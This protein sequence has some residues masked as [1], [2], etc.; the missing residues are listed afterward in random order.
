MESSDS[1]E[2]P[3]DKALR[4]SYAGHMIR[5]KWRR[6]RR[7]EQERAVL[8]DDEEQE[9]EN[10]GSSSKRQKPQGDWRSSQVGPPIQMYEEEEVKEKGDDNANQATLPYAI[11]NTLPA[12]T[13]ES[14]PVQKEVD[15]FLTKHLNHLPH[16]AG[17]A[18]KYGTNQALKLRYWRALILCYP[19][20]YLGPEV[21]K[22]SKF[23]AVHTSAKKPLKK[24]LRLVKKTLKQLRKQLSNRGD[25][26]R[27][28]MQRP[29]FGR[30][31]LSITT[32]RS[33]VHNR[34]LRAL[35]VAAV[36]PTKGVSGYRTTKA[37]TVKIP[38]LL[39]DK[40]QDKLPKLTEANK[41]SDVVIPAPLLTAFIQRI[42]QAVGQ[43]ADTAGGLSGSIGPAFV[44]FATQLKLSG[45]WK[46]LGNLPRTFDPALHGYVVKVPHVAPGNVLLW[47]EF[48][49]SAG[50]D[51]SL[52]EP[53]ITCFVDFVPSNLLTPEQRVYYRWHA[54]HAPVDLGAGS[55]RGQWFD[56]V[57]KVK[58]EQ[59]TFGLSP[60]IMHKFER[61]YAART[62]NSVARDSMA[63]MMSADRQIQLGDGKVAALELV[64]FTT[65]ALLGGE[66]PLLRTD[67]FD[68]ML[69]GLREVDRSVWTHNTMFGN[70]PLRG[71]AAFGTGTY[72]FSQTTVTALPLST[73]P[74]LQEF[75]EW[76]NI[77]WNTRFDFALAAWYPAQNT[78]KPARLPWHADD[79]PFIAPDS[80]IV[81]VS[82]A[83][84]MR[85]K[86]RPNADQRNIKEI[87]THHGQVYAMTG[88]FQSLYEH[89]VVP[90][91]PTQRKT[92][93]KD[94]AYVL[95]DERFSITLRQSATPQTSQSSSSSSS[96]SSPA[97]QPSSSSSSSSSFSSSRRAHQALLRNQQ[98]KHLKEF[99]YLVVPTPADVQQAYPP[100][101][102]VKN[103]SSFFKHA[104]LTDEK[105]DMRQRKYVQAANKQKK[106]LELRGNSFF[107]YSQKPPPDDELN[108]VVGGIHAHN[109]QNGGSLLA[110]NSGLG[111]GVSFFSEP[112]HV[113]FQF[114]DFVF[115]LLNTFYDVHE[116]DDTSLLVVLERFRVKDQADWTGGTH[117]D[118]TALSTIP[119][120][121][122][123]ILKLDDMSEDEDIDE[124]HEEETKEGESADPN[125]EEDDMEEDTEDI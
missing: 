108:P 18:A 73:V 65:P 41:D 48:H 105:F 99:G 42:Y 75:V 22:D 100:V 44:A 81:G 26:Q 91:T 59:E 120:S 124:Q 97:V 50:T 20:R 98:A 29:L 45:A 13:T 66:S 107:Y 17:T 43:K 115:R 78:A 89:L 94:K 93:Q 47:S 62:R 19:D 74:G 119:L 110:A 96:S 61:T 49:A 2:T 7:R 85:F 79:E 38:F 36:H 121:A 37:S 72:K 84:A 53:K 116:D 117:I 58:Q 24:I 70:K 123:K 56:F 69:A 5:K 25:T 80:T 88:K 15:A 90:L 67:V 57:H 77:T 60:E 111:R 14:H 52:E 32:S 83:S 64:K 122:Q 55:G 54:R 10:E 34:A 39:P 63:P 27:L 104:T 101:Q 30:S 103:L 114:S 109:A 71:H 1:D 9:E 40:L 92:F 51:V 4:K 118:T 23:G 106:A 33:G 86:T 125:M 31:L 76:A 82:L 46:A 16:H 28:Q 21:I 112:T 113:G 35:V 102:S 87:V 68:R 12:N 3:A 6:K 95:G 8:E 11:I